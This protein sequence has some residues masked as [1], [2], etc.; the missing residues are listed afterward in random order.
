MP[1]ISQHWFIMRRFV[2]DIIYY[3]FHLEN[4]KII[5]EFSIVSHILRKCID[6]E[7]RNKKR[8]DNVAITFFCINPNDKMLYLY[9][10]MIRLNP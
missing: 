6:L 8:A 7:F 9:I 1:S 3:S 10:K 4:E 2:I 5:L